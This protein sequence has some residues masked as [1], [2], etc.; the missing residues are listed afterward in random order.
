MNYYYLTG[1]N[2]AA[3]VGDSIILSTE[4]DV[5]VFVVDCMNDDDIV[6]DDNNDDDGVVDV[7]ELF[8][9]DVV[10]LLFDVVDDDDDDDDDEFTS[11]FVVETIYKNKKISIF[12]INKIIIFTFVVVIVVVVGIGV[13]DKVGQLL[14]ESTI[15]LIW[16]L[17]HYKN[18]GVKK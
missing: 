3:F 18:K 14:L 12:Q 9:I 10:L 15:S 5:V 1:K 6:V 7:V 4:K 17:L 13:G 8:T 2:H 16:C 11:L